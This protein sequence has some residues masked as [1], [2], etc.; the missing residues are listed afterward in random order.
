MQRKVTFSEN[1]KNEL[2]SNGISQERLAQY[3][4][5]TQATVSRWA[6]GENQ[7]D[8]DYLFKICELLEVSP[9]DI[10]GWND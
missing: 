9:N 4:G 10:L 8:F 5:T 1:L 6:N 3:L 7:P 2:K